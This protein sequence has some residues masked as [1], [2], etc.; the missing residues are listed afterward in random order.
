M[1]EKPPQTNFKERQNPKPV[2]PDYRKALEY[3]DNIASLAPV[4]RQ[5]HVQAQEASQQL[6]G[7]IAELEQLKAPK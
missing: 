5:G 4:S 7:A 3:L 6:S 1:A 2:P